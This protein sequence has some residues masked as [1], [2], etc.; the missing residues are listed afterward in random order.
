MLKE[1][2]V[3]DCNGIY[4]TYDSTLTKCT[5][6]QFSQ[7]DI[8]R[9]DSLDPKVLKRRAWLRTLAKHK[10]P[11][12][13][14]YHVG[15]HIFIMLD[16]KLHAQITKLHADEDNNIEVRIGGSKRRILVRPESI[17]RIKSGT[18]IWK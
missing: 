4:E 13:Q 6:C 18:T 3:L 14:D 17:V 8:T 15:E 16:K 1:C 5:S 7:N 9:C 12:T 10:V 2:D 11:Y